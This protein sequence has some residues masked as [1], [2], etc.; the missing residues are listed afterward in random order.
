MILSLFRGEFEDED[1]LAAGLSVF[2]DSVFAD[3][4]MDLTHKSVS[5][6]LG[7]TKMFCVN[8]FIRFSIKIAFQGRSWVTTNK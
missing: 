2:A 8:G 4:A 5:T 7:R 6:I 1:V 3:V